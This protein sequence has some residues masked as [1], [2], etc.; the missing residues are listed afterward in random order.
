MKYTVPDP[1]R[2]SELRHEL[3][4][5]EHR[6]DPFYDK[7][8]PHDADD[9][10]HKSRQ[11][12]QAVRLL[13]QNPAFHRYLLP[14]Q[15]EKQCSTRDHSQTSDLDEDHHYHLPE[16]SILFRR[17]DCDK[18]GHTDRRHGCKQCID[19]FDRFLITDRQPQDNAAQKNHSEKAQCYNLHC[20]Q[21]DPSG[22]FFSPV[23]NILLIHS[24]P[25]SPGADP[26]S[27]SVYVRARTVLPRPLRTAIL[28]QAYVR[29]N[30]RMPFRAF[31]GDFLTV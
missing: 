15:Q 31:L 9:K 10:F 21:P 1:L 25:A 18:P 27:Q 7:S 24:S 29:F 8:P 4:R 23:H 11:C 14:E 17:D 13:D 19:E 30:F 26:P 2:Q 28:T 3:D 22:A 20:I 16:Q 5:E 12:I 6:S